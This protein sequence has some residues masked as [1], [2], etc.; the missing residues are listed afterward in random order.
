MSYLAETC[1]KCID[2]TYSANY[3]FYQTTIL[4][5]ETEKEKTTTEYA[6]VTVT[7]APTYITGFPPY[8]RS[9]LTYKHYLLRERKIG[10]AYSRISYEHTVRD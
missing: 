8:I 5:G 6:E 3:K 7:V 4:R 1:Q 2:S 10:T 9:C